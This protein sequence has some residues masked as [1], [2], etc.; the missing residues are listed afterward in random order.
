[1]RKKWVELNTTHCKAALYF[2]LFSFFVFL[3]FLIIINLFMCFLIHKYKKHRIVIVIIL[4]F[5]PLKLKVSLP[6]PLDFREPMA[7][8]TFT[9][10][11]CPSGLINPHSESSMKIPA[12][13][14]LW[15]CLNRFT[16]GSFVFLSK[17]QQRSFCHL[18]LKAPKQDKNK[19]I[20]K[21]LFFAIPKGYWPDS[22]SRALKQTCNK[23]LFCN[24]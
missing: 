1:M 24:A 11:C 18:F 10:L 7:H 20:T 2:S 22:S 17:M 14:L 6:H 23:T 5:V 19:V 12:A 3:L 4:I 21:S 16:T 9:L 13:I 8:I 15:L